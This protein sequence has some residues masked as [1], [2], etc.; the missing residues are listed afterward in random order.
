[1]RLLVAQHLHAIFELPK[2]EVRGAQAVWRS[3][4]LNAPMCSQIASAGSK[5]RLRM[6]SS[7]PPRINCSSCTMNSI[8]RMPPG[9]S[10]R[11]LRQVLARNLGVDQRLHLAQPGEAV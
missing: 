2:Q 11:V 4:G 6:P 9:P 5:P 7:R 10:F 1:V 8:S 3:P